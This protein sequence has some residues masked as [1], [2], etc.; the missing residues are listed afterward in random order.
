MMRQ[1]GKECKSKS[2]DVRDVRVFWREIMIAGVT[3]IRQNKNVT[4]YH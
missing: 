2:V 1:A 3:L 4:E